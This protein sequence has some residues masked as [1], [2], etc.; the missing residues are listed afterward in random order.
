MNYVQLC[1]DCRIKRNW[2]W[3]AFSKY[4]SNEKFHEYSQNY[5][6]WK[7]RKY[8]RN[9]TKYLGLE[10]G[11][12]IYEVSLLLPESNVTLLKLWK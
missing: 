12:L 11:N 10:I 6:L 8:L 7:P 1:Y 4:S 9:L 5:E 2:K 3:A